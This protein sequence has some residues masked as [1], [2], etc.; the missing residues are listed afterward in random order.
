MSVL[1]HEE[2]EE[3]VRD[4]RLIES[5]SPHSLQGASY[6]MRLGKEYS[7]EGARFNLD[8]KSPSIV[9]EHSRAISSA[10]AIT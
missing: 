8:E 5:F 1:I 2:I 4:Q 10:A 3:L 6:D 7:R 9:M